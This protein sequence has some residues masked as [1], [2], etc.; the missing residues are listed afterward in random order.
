MH[1]GA[2]LKRMFGWTA[3]QL[4][5]WPLP[6]RPLR[7]S[8][9]VFT[10]ISECFQICNQSGFVFDG[11]LQSK[12]VTRNCAGLNVVTPETRRYII[13]AQPLR[14][15]PVFKRRNRAAMLEHVPVPHASERRDF[16]VSGSPPGIHRQVRVGAD[17]SPQN[18]VLLNM[19]FR[20]LK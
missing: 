14:I 10:V 7:G 19:I 4:P 1:T 13:L 12:L 5:E 9:V 2:G 20:N 15:E 11:Q 18:V 6:R 3:T 17:R 8:V 16:V